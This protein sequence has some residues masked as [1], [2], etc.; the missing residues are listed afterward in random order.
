M[1]PNKDFEDYWMRIQLLDIPDHLATRILGEIQEII[2]GYT[3]RLQLEIYKLMFYD[4]LFIINSRF[5]EEAKK[6]FEQVKKAIRSD[7]YGQ[8]G[9]A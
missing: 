3:E 7:T 1:R 2:Q 5:D 8:Q 9:D 6:I 4:E